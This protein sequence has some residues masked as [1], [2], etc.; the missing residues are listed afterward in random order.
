MEDLETNIRLDPRVAAVVH[1]RKSDYFEFY[2]YV[3]YVLVVL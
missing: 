1:S 2:M 3:L